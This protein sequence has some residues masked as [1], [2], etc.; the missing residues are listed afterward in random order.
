MGRL[1]ARIAK[2]TCASPRRCLLRHGISRLPASDIKCV[3]QCLVLRS[4]CS[5]SS[6]E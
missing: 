4:A 1:R 2:L 6:G 3:Q 5:L